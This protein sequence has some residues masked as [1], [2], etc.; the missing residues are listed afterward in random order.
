MV[1][2]VVLR[3]DHLHVGSGRDFRNEA[4][5]VDINPHCHPDLVL[6]LSKPL[7][8]SVYCEQ[9]AGAGR[10]AAKS[11]IAQRLSAGDSRN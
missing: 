11:E 7:E 1:K 3:P 10:S 2:N 4:L 8:L 6:D 9:I 5:N